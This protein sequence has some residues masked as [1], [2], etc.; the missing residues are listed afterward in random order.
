MID[1]EAGSGKTTFVKAICG[2]WATT[3]IETKRKYKDYEYMKTFDILLVF[4]LRNALSNQTL[5]ELL[6]TQFSDLTFT[7]IY[8]IL[9]LVKNQPEKTCIIFDGL[10]E[11]KQ[12]KQTEGSRNALLDIITRQAEKDVVSITTTRPQGLI[13]LQRYSSQPFQVHV[14]LCG[15]KK[16]QIEE[17]T[18]KYFKNDTNTAQEMLKSIEKKKKWHLARIPIRLQMMC[19]VWKSNRSFGE[20]TAD[21]Y[22]ML[23]MGLIDHMEKRNERT[24]TRE[25]KVQTEYQDD[26]LLRTGELANT[27]DEYGNLK[28]LFSISDIEASI[29]KNYQDILDFGCLTRYFPTSIMKN[30]L[31]NFTHLSLQEYF[32]AYNIA[33]SSNQQVFQKFLKQC[34]SI[35]AIEIHTLIIE[36]MCNLAPEKAN[37]VITQVVKRVASEHECNTM[38]SYLLKFMEAYK[39]YSAAD[40][41]LPKQV[42]T[43][44]AMK[45]SIIDPIRL[46]YLDH[47]IRRDCEKHKNM[48]FL[49]VS[50][51][52]EITDDIN[53][54]HLLGLN[55]SIKERNQIQKASKFLSNISRKTKQLDMSITDS[56]IT[57]SDIETLCNNFKSNTLEIM[58]LVGHGV[59]LIAQKMII[60]QQN[61]CSLTLQNSQDKSNKKQLSG[62]CK[63]LQ[64]KQKFKELNLTDFRIDENIS[65]LRKS[66][67]VTLKNKFDQIEDFDDFARNLSRCK[68]KITTL[69]LSLSN[70]SETTTKMQPCEVLG[71]LLVNMHELEVLK[72]RKCGLTTNALFRIAGNISDTS[73]VSVQELD[74]LGNHFDNSQEDLEKLQTYFPHLQVLLFTYFQDGPVVPNISLSKLMVSGTNQKEPVSLGETTMQLYELYMI[75]CFPKFSKADILKKLKTLC[76][77]N[78][79]KEACDICFLSLTEALTYMP[80]LKELVF[81]T[82]VYQERKI[83]D[84]NG[85]VRSLPPLLKYLNLYGYYC[86]PITHILQEKHHLKKLRKLNIGCNEMDEEHLQVIRQELQ[87]LNSEINVYSDKDESITRLLFCSVNPPSEINMRS[88]A[89]VQELLNVLK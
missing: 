61:L 69:D 88:V 43:S 63:E 44:V 78:L 51:L 80:S 66:V 10:D 84:I 37:E 2:A 13:E 42:S 34:S 30:V 76:I 54:E 56:G 50:D 49:T 28:I 14:K 21:L 24:L 55:I 71:G 40:F 12:M 33:K 52:N 29:G 41:P 32:V 19:F 15:F 8:F 31:W 65:S 1:G 4:I 57:E 3:V 5:M 67:K 23:I 46:S 73:K 26:L 89:E 25:D 22:N 62:I 38:L 53:I 16:D 83:N 72:L 75:Y 68:S 18:R 45:E 27:W 79:N 70:F 20:N 9:Q 47:L 48:A 87:Y 36:I 86:K 60:Q 59:V 17:Y 85:L 7:E 35:R 82:N 74:L 77:L 11:L 39:E 58:S 81:A 6:K 64:S